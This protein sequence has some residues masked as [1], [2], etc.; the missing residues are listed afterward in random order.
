MGVEAAGA[1][2]NYGLE[3]NHV[4]QPSTECHQSRQI[5]NEISFKAKMVIWCGARLEPRR[6]AV[7]GK[8]STLPAVRCSMAAGVEEWKVLP[9]EANDILVFITQ[10]TN[11]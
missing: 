2:L 4:S 6:D 5:E 9:C 11:S 10:R 7:R 8:S 3:Q 1:K